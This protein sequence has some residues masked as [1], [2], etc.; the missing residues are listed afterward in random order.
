MKRRICHVC[1]ELMEAPTYDELLMIRREH[2]FYCS[3]ISAPA[4]GM[5][6]VLIE[7]LEALWFRDRIGDTDRY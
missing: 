5:L 6:K 3:G 2:L 7:D 1:G 4:Y